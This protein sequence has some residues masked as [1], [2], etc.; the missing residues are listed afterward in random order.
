MEDTAVR[1]RAERRAHALAML[2]SMNAEAWVASASPSGERHLVPLSTVWDGRRI[3]VAVDRRSAT[4]RNL[5]AT[6][7]ARVALGQTGDVVMIDTALNKSVDVDSAPAEVAS[8]FADQADW[9]PRDAGGPSEGY[10]Y[11]CLLPERVQVWRSVAE[12]RGRDHA[13]RSLARLTR[14]SVSAEHVGQQRRGFLRYPHCEPR[15]ACCEVQRE[16]KEWAAQL[17]CCG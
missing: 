14:K 2:Q 8:A 1:T 5:A 11:L 16:L 17:L 9:D 10:V 13:C 6:R 7:K 3:I 4:A 12:H 15:L